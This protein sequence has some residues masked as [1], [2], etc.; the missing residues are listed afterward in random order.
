MQKYHKL[1]I[2]ETSQ[3]FLTRPMVSTV[4]NDHRNGHFG[5]YVNFLSGQLQSNLVWPSQLLPLVREIVDMDKGQQLI[6]WWIN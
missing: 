1:A 6:W 5:H 3:T 2:K 4:L